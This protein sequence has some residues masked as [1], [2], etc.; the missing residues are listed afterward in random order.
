[1]TAPRRLTLRH[2]QPEDL[3]AIMAIEEASFALPWPASA[4]AQDLAGTGGACYW[5][6]TLEDA[7]VAYLGSWLFE[8][9]FHVGSLATAPEHR[10]RGLGKLL[11]LCALR[12]A[13][14]RGAENAFLEHRVSNEPAARLYADLGFRKLRVRRRYYADNGEDA[15]E[16][17]F[18]G[19]HQDT[20]RLRLEQETDNWLR[21][22]DYDVRLTE[23]ECP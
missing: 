5:V 15:I 14:G 11:M 3:P 23:F 6:V 18:A 22:H 20:T 2:A 21:D 13:A 17:V 7:V 16:L 4:I 10:R 12:Y 1:V 8:L 9:D 19:L